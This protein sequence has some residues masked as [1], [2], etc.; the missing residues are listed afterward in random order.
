MASLNDLITET[1][2]GGNPIITQASS[3]RS[4]G[5]STL[6][7]NSLQN[8][9]IKTAI[10][11][12]TYQVTTVNGVNVKV[13]GTQTDWKAVVSGSSLEDLTWEGGAAD[14]GN[15]IGDYIEMTP[16]YSWAQ[17]LATA[18][19]LQHA[20]TGAHVAI[21]NTS[22]LINAG[23]LTTDALSVTGNV[24]VGGTLPA[25]SLYNPYKF[26]VYRNGSLTLSTGAQV[27]TFDTKTFD[28]GSNVDVVT[29]KGRF[30][31]PIAG[32]YFFT[33]S[34][35]VTQGNPYTYQIAI[36]KNGSTVLS[37]N[38]LTSANSNSGAYVVSG[39]VQLATNDY[40]EIYA[41]TSNS[42]GQS[43]NVGASSAYFQGFLVSVS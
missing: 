19:E 29:N 27:V 24:T 33:S 12:Q 11:F 23:G 16:T 22:G 30:T 6:N 13:V 15:S 36:A 38:E 39:L 2:N 21:N 32:F 28:T 42:G 31:A 35:S 1:K 10:H 26:S 3:P 9:P 41:S 14:A 34:V 20:T 43:V 7:A 8:W 17:D 37:G 4:I 5:G 25:A 40:V 18:I